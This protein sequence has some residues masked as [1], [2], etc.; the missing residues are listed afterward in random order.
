MTVAVVIAYLLARLTYRP[1]ARLLEKVGRKKQD[2]LYGLE[3][4]EH[5]YEELKVEKEDMEELANQYYQIGQNGFLVS[6]LMGML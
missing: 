5:V 3:E 4:I 1:I 6:L 2:G